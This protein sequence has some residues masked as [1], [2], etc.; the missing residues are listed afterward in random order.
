MIRAGAWRAGRLL[1]ACGT[2]GSLALG[3]TGTA[4]QTRLTTASGEYQLRVMS[5]AEIPFRTV[6]K[7]QNDFSCGSAAVAT[8]LSFHFN[9]PTP[10][11]PIFQAMWSAGDQPAIRKLGFSML[12]M[13]R[14][15]DAIGFRTEGYR[16]TP[17]QVRTLDKPGIILLNLRGYMHFVVVKGMIKDQ[18]LVGDPMLG[19]MRYS[20]ADLMAHWN[21]IFLTVVDSPDHGRPRFNVASEWRL[22]ST[23][24]LG[25]G[26]LR[27]S[28]ASVTDNLPPLYQIAS[29]ATG[30]GS[31]A[32]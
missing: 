29:P 13:K 23:A 14:Y 22:W 7:Q 3:S 19:L 24:P 25:E 6:V 10:E 18:M 9:R 4:A 12:D 16:L 11:R 8:L 21:G 28:I 26:D 27:S 17:D 15:L 32:P 31:A 20:T 1:I 5:W 2:C 30:V